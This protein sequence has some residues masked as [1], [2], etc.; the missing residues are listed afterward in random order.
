MFKIIL[1][2]RVYETDTGMAMAWAWPKPDRRHA[3]I[4]HGRN[5]A[6]LY[7]ASASVRLVLDLVGRLY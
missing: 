1:T 4:G 3:P 2:D 7:W 6:L 5:Y